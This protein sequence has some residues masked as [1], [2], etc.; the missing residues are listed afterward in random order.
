MH[1]WTLRLYTLAAIYLPP[2][3]RAMIVW[4]GRG[5]EK[6]YSAWRGGHARRM[7]MHEERGRRRRRLQGQRQ[8]GEEDGSESISS[9]HPKD[10]KE[11]KKEREGVSKADEK[12]PLVVAAEGASGCPFAMVFAPGDGGGH[13]H[14]HEGEAAADGK[15]GMDAR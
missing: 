2:V 15:D 3:R 13:G 6:F 7:K 12:S 8:R 14:G 4:H 9:P 5:T 1:L 10:Q 11:G